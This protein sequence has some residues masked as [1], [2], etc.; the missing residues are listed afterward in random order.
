MTFAIPADHHMLCP[1]CSGTGS[2]LRPRAAAIR[3]LVMSTAVVEEECLPCE[4]TGWIPPRHPEPRGNV[5]GQE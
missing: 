5:E 3:T 1:T 4:G 2:R